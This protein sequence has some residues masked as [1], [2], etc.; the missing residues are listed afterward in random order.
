MLYDFASQPLSVGD[1]L[2]FQE[3]SLVLRAT[4]DLGKIDFA[5]VYD[6]L[7]PVVPDPAFA[8]IDAESF[9]YYVSS[10]LPAAQVN[11][12]L[13]AVLFFDS[14]AAL[15]SYIKDNANRYHVWPSLGQYAGREYLL[16][17]CY[18]H[19]FYD[20]FQQYRTL[21]RLSSRPAAHAWAERFLDEHVGPATAI[22]VQLRRNPKNPARNS[23]YEAWLTFLSRCAD[24]YPAKFIVI[25]AHDE[26]DVRFRTL[27]NVVVAKDHGTSVEQDLAL[28]EIARI[29][30]G[31]SS[32]PGTMAQF[33]EKPYCLFNSLMDNEFVRGFRRDGDHGRFLFSNSLQNWVIGTETAELTDTAH[34]S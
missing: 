11:P 8:Y 29:H 2:I 27:K 21:P 7:S 19:L 5:V 23:S 24:R 13:G 17:Y 6:P 18:N 9:L 20:Y 31:A 26:I 25:C 14:H 28:I 15:E 10:F 16:Y 34:L 3:S 30:M 32:G 22:T 33:S 12:H 1:I 4:H